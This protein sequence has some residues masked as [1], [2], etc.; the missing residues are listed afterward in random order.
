M[1][2]SGG[3]VGVGSAGVHLGSQSGYQASG[4]LL[5]GGENG[6]GLTGES[7]IDVRQNNT[8]SSSKDH[9]SSSI[10]TLRLK[11]REHSIALGTI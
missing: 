9:K 11:A 3:S 6:H 7:N 1:A 5:V 4:M 2:S 10:S 8:D